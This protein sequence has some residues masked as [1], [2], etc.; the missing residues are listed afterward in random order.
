MTACEMHASQRAAQLT[1][2]RPIESSV[3]IMTIAVSF[4]FISFIVFI[5]LHIAT[6]AAST[7]GVN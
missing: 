2:R 3:S 1:V 5:S 6:H 7:H 4:V